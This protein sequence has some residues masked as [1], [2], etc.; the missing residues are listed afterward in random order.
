MSKIIHTGGGIF[1]DTEPVAAP[2]GM[3]DDPNV[4]IY[5]YARFRSME[6]VA[7]G[8][9]RT[10]GGPEDEEI[11]SEKVG[12]YGMEPRA[13]YWQFNDAMDELERGGRG[14]RSGR[15]Y[16]F[17][18]TPYV[19]VTDEEDFDTALEALGLDPDDSAWEGPGLYDFR[20]EP[21][22]FQGSVEEYEEESLTEE[23][24]Q[25]IEFM[26]QGDEW[27]DTYRALAGTEEGD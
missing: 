3:D 26:F 15:L 21:P 9:F 14:K 1:V 25:A 8:L 12:E 5:A 24:D 2:D 10:T 13:P 4:H 20:D 11:E 17:E 6:H 16:A 27:E 18:E 22:T 7:Y 19:E 23:A